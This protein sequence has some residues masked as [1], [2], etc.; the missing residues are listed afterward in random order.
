LTDPAKFLESLLQFDKDNI[1]DAVIAKIEP[2]LANEA[3][4][5][6]QVVLALATFP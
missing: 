1:P 2:F 6:E 5:P 3:F 4:T